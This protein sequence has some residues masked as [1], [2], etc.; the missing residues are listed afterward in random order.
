MNSL[1]GIKI[2][3]VDDEKD[4]CNIMEDHFQAEGAQC[5][6]AHNGVEALKLFHQYELDFVITDIRMPKMGGE[7]LTQEIRRLDANIPIVCVS[8]YSIYQEGD[9]STWGADAFQEKPLNL[10]SMV[11]LIRTLHKRAQIRISKS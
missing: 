2:L 9:I 4:L 6:A 5:I 1:E 8:G 11:S 3:I 7:Q 10:N